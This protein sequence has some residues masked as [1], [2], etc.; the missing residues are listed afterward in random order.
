M[1]STR[2]NG[3]KTY[4]QTIIMKK[5]TRGGKRPNSGRKPGGKGRTNRSASISMHPHVWSK[6]DKIRK[7]R[8]KSHAIAEMITNFPCPASADA[9]KTPASSND[10][11]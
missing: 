6:L 10:D 3:T 1:P 2:N 11:C 5:P 4:T 8:P 7:G 9:E